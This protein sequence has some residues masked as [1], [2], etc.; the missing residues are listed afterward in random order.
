MNPMMAAKFGGPPMQS[1]QTGMG[2]MV[3]MQKHIMGNNPY[4][5]TN[6]SIMT[7][8]PD[9]YSTPSQMYN[10]MHSGS[11]SNSGSGGG[12]GG[13]GSG[14]FIPSHQTQQQAPSTA[15]FVND[16]DFDLSEDLLTAP[17]LTATTTG[18]GS[19][20]TSTA[21]AAVSSSSADL[22]FAGSQSSGDFSASATSATTTLTSMLASSSG[23]Y[24]QPSQPPH[25]SQMYHQ[26]YDGSNS[27]SSS[28]SNT[29]LYPNMSF[30][31]VPLIDEPSMSRL[32]PA[33]SS[34][35]IQLLE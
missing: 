32:A 21:A 20:T 29:N 30:V 26:P 8:N 15:D 3:N 33:N 17:I 7:P 9:L 35:L 18:T 13:G 23:V 10:S 34:S 19:T 16:D 5:N 12:G 1:Q 14:S 31:D 22:F 11:G 27:T 2:Q 25:P 4:A 24:S 6:G 28:S